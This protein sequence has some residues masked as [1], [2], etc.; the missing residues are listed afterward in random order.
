MNEAVICTDNPNL[1]NLDLPSIIF[2]KE[3]KKKKK[4]L[5][6]FVYNIFY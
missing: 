3:K 5:N 2:K 6:I 4:Y 1:A